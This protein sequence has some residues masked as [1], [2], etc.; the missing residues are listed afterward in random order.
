MQS[1]LPEPK[2]ITV[3]GGPFHSGR[4][5]GELPSPAA[6]AFQN[7]ELTVVNYQFLEC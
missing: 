1:R 3:S 7:T 4:Y 6:D 2:T 5:R